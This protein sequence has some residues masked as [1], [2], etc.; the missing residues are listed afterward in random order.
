MSKPTIRFYLLLFASASVLAGTAWWSKGRG[1]SATLLAKAQT[2]KE[3]MSHAQDMLLEADSHENLAKKQIAG[4]SY[5]WASLTNGEH[6]RDILVQGDAKS[7]RD[8][9]R[10]IKGIQ[11][12]EGVRLVHHVGKVGLLE[13]LNSNLSLKRDRKSSANQTSTTITIS[14]RLAITQSSELSGLVTEAIS[15]NETSSEIILHNKLFLDDKLD[16][17]PASLGL[18]RIALRNPD[19][20]SLFY[21]ESTCEIVLARTMK[22][23][24]RLQAQ[25]RIEDETSK[26]IADEVKLTVR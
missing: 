11:A 23:D 14:G 8:L 2:V 12:V 4:G 5:D 24:T 21:D 25:A 1:M 9:A 10:L 26:L 22:E 18:L 7:A 3:Q 13:D 16:R 6:A 15:N 19:I 17:H 20:Q